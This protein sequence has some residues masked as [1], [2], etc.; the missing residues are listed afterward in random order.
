MQRV[1][2]MP[3]S[4][5]DIDPI[6]SAGNGRMAAIEKMAA[7][8]GWRVWADLRPSLVSDSHGRIN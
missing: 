1:G 5:D 3:H 4:H 6:G 2:S 7:R 8:I